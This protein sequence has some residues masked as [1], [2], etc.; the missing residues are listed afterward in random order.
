MLLNILVKFLRHSEKIKNKK[1]GERKGV[2]R[3]CGK[4]RC[5]REVPSRNLRGETAS[6]IFSGLES[7]HDFIFVII[8]Q[9]QHTGPS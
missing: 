9:K 5:I 4:V 1:K 8:C 2:G 3:K 6:F 7:A